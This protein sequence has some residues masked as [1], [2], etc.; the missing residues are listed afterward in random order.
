MHLDFDLKA[1]FEPDSVAVVGASH[2]KDKVGHLIL[3]NLTKGGYNGKIFPVNPKGGTILELEVLTSI[4]QLPENTDL[5][6][7]CLPRDLVLEAAAELAE[8]KVSAV[9]IVS[10]GFKE[11]GR[12]GYDIEEKLRTLAEKNSMA[13]LGP[14]CLGLINTS[15]NLNASFAQDRPKA[16]G[17][18]FFSQSGALCASILDWAL[19]ENIGFSKFISL[20][21]KA[22]LNESHMLEALNK[23]KDTRVVLGY[24]ESLEDGQRLVRT[25]QAVTANKPVIMIKAGTTPAGARATSSH[26]GAIAGSREAFRAAFLQSGII[27]AN[28]LKTLL[29]LARSF[30]SQPLPK[31]PNLMIVTNS[32]GPGILAADACENSS[33]ALARPSADTLEKLRQELPPFAALYNPVDIIGDADAERYR[34]TMEIVAQDDLVHAI[35]VVLSPTASVE[36]EETAKAVISM[37][38]ECGK[39]VF[40]CFM[41]GERIGAGSRMLLDAGIPCYPFP[42]PA[43]QAIEAMYRY[44]QWQNRAY[45]VDVCFRRDKGMAQK[46][47]DK[48]KKAHQTEITDFDAQGLARAY[49]LP[50]P[51]TRMARTSDKAIRAAKQ[52]GYPV[53]LKI[54]SPHIQEKSSIQGVVK[55]LNK[56]SEVRQAF[57]DITS[58]AARQRPDAYISGCLVQAMAPEDSMEVT[59]G[60]KRDPQFGPLIMF[61][62]GGVHTEIL[63]DYS[64]RLAP[65]TLNDAQEIVRGIKSFSLLKG[66]RGKAPMDIGIIEDILLTVSQ[67]A[68]DFPEIQEA[69][70]HPILVSENGALITDMRM[71]IG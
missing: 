31:G 44:H 3:S 55:G 16:G 70:F 43:I 22:V 49:E 67:M 9:I 50:V 23:D 47:L 66:V 65:L 10:A 52:I 4:A 26:T 57:Y 69:L 45:P 34:K 6:V 38:A 63:N 5:A 1:L 61:G 17:I 71:T 35:L 28:D 41:G 2:D 12:E 46:F 15:A 29:T 8:K 53:V 25:A 37:A 33:L 27:Q 30:A 19:G 39:P 51:E 18:A 48:A 62:L 13:L 60:L 21:N 36:I 68:V 56:P 7:I 11:T 54:A 20:G 42:E 59:I 24:C 14:N 64:Y 32:G 58:R 40:T